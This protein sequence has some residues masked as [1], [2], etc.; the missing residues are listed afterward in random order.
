MD[1]V[2]IGDLLIQHGVITNCKECFD[3]FLPG[4]H[5]LDKKYQVAQFL[6]Q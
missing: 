2:L 4:A 5:F 1:P 6:L 3:G